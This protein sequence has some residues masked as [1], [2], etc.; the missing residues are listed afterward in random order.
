MKEGVFFAKILCRNTS[1][2]VEVDAR[3]SDAIAIAVRF[4]APIF[5]AESVMSEASIEFNEEEDKN[6]LKKS[7]KVPRQGSVTSGKPADSLKDFSL[8]KLNHLLDEAIKNEDYERAAR[9]R[10]E[11]NKRN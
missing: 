3:P 2:S 8:D 11:I 5:C 7:G 6:E 10:D 9:I 4:D 1:K